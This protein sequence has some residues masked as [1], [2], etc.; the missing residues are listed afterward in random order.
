MFSFEVSEQA[1]PLYCHA[2]NTDVTYRANNFSTDTNLEITSFDKGPRWYNNENL[3]LT[4]LISETTF[5]L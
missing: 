4:S 5:H 2:N 3:F 1:R